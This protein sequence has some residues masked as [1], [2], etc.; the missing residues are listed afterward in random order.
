MEWFHG[1]LASANAVVI[2][3]NITI[4]GAG[5]VSVA[6]VR[7]VANHRIDDRIGG[8]VDRRCE[9]GGKNHEKDKGTKGKHGYKG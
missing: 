7:L 8:R 9:N 1:C 2:G 6:A 5:F 3:L 4:H